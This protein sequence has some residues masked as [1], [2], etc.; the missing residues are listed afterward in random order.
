[1]CVVCARQG[2]ALDRLLIST[3][4]MRYAILAWDEATKSIRTL[5]KG[6]IEVSASFVLCCVFLLFLTLLFICCVAP[7]WT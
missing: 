1:M 6:N 3:E 7:V 4:N 2:A 5:Q